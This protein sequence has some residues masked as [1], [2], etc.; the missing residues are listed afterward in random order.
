MQNFNYNNNIYQSHPVKFDDYISNKYNIIHEQLFNDALYKAWKSF[1]DN[2]SIKIS[3]NDKVI[4]HND[5]GDDCYVMNTRT[6]DDFVDSKGKQHF[7]YY[8]DKHLIDKF[9]DFRT[10]ISIIEIKSSEYWMPSS[11]IW[12]L[13]K[14]PFFTLSPHGNYNKNNP[15]NFWR[16]KRRGTL[17]LSPWWN[18][19]YNNFSDDTQDINPN[20]EITYLNYITGKATLYNRQDDKEIEIDFNKVTGNMKVSEEYSLDKTFIS[21]LQRENR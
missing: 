6:N 5:N 17:D 13:K 1:K 10:N 12:K 9:E 15:I 2:L 11:V 20:Y 21:K 18:S 16:F 19:E 3:L 4:Y 7:L 8:L 14:W